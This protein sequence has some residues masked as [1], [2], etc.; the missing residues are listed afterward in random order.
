MSLEQSQLIVSA[1][2]LLE[3]VNP[4]WLDAITNRPSGSQWGRVLK[5]WTEIANLRWERLSITER[6]DGLHLPQCIYFHY[7][8]HAEDEDAIGLHPNATEN[9]RL[10]SE[11]TDFSS[12]RIEKGAHGLELVSDEVQPRQTREAWL[13]IG[14]RQ[15]EQYPPEIVWTAYPGRLA[16]SPV[17]HKLWDGTLNCL[18]PL[19]RENI[20]IAVKG[21]I[22]SS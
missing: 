18:G 14:P 16:V 22:K 13:I 20:P 6:I 10:L 11:F 21:K 9:I 4:Q 5:G 2:Q 7:Q 17:N 1:F 8:K 12:I 3:E 19:S 15:G